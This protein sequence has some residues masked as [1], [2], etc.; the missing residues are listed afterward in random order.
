MQNDAGEFVDLYVPRKC[1]A[2]NRII[3]AKDHASIQINLAEVDK[4]TG[5][6]NGQHRTYAICGAIRRMGESDDCILRLSK[7]NGIVT[8]TI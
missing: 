7:N 5:R 8:K 4:V 3:A 2:S 1:S 6:F